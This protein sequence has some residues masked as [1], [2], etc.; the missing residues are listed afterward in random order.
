MAA[1]KLKNTANKTESVHD[2]KKYKKEQNFVVKLNNNCKKVFFF[3][4]L[5]IENNSKLFWG[6]CKPYF[7]KTHS[8]GNCNIVLIE[9]NELLLK[10]QKVAD[11]FNSHF[12]SITN[13]LDLF[14]WALGSTDQIYDSVGRIIDSFY[15]HP[16]IITEL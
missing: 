6:K 10:N 13:F 8:K 11:M 3:G 1:S 4:N 2:L 7:S 9:K 14:E 15:F 5:E 16:S 12:Q